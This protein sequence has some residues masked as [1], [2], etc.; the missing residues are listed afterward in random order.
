V[1]KRVKRIPNAFEGFG[2]I[3]GAVLGIFGLLLSLSS[4]GAASRLDARR[5]LIVNEAN[6]IS[7]AYMR[8]DLLPNA[9]QPE[10]RR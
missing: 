7:G 4:C 6:A 9:A 8:V 3:E 1:S 10:A 2:A 5:Q